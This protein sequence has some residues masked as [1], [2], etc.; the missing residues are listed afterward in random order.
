MK[1]IIIIIVIFTVS[2]AHARQCRIY[3]K[4]LRS[5]PNSSKCSGKKMHL[6][7]DD[8]PHLVFTK[9][10]LDVLKAANVPATFFVSTYN[11]DEKYLREIERKANRNA[12]KSESTSSINTRVKRNIKVREA[13]T[14]RIS[15]DQSL[16]LAT[17]AHLHEA[18]DSRIR[19]GKKVKSFDEEESAHE[20][21]HSLDILNK[22]TGNGMSKQGSNQLIRFPF[23]RGI[24]PAA[25]EFNEIRQREGM[26]ST[27]TK[28][29]Y[30]KKY[31]HAMRNASKLN[32]SHLRWN[33]DSSDSV[34]YTNNVKNIN[35]NDYI[36]EFITN[37]CTKG[38]QNLISLLHDI[39]K[40]NAL[41]SKRYSNKIV[42]EEIIEKL[43]CLGV[44]FVSANE[45]KKKNLPLNV[46]TPAS[47]VIHDDLN[48][49]LKPIINNSIT[50][51]AEIVACGSKDKIAH[52]ASGG[53]T[54]QITGA[55]FEKCNGTKGWLCYK[56]KWFSREKL[57]KPQTINEM[58]AKKA[59]ESS[60][61][62]Y[63]SYLKRQINHCDP[64]T[65]KICFDGKFRV[66]KDFEQFCEQ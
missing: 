24:A 47:A 58:M 21:E 49:I 41:P 48:T 63:S 35:T 61:D 22:I 56:D 45:I 40:V 36:E 37:A 53:C 4:D 11:F 33:H 66:R 8:G 29:D 32:L 5:I 1:P 20:I 28:D 10:I 13:L 27:E 46:F 15:D 52:T 17:H 64:S 7:F 9:K 30:I 19:Y 39:Q 23:A 65:E 6:T 54:H 38:G 42:I 50:P 43:K 62:C 2:L 34:K 25:I 26:K 18:H 16:T 3:K 55:H 31:S 60:A 51:G 59:C 44:D 57:K 12:G 14:R